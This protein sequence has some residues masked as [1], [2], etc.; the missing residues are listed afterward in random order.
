MSNSITYLTTRTTFLQVSPDIPVTK[1]RPEEKYDPPD[2]FDAN[3]KEM[4]HDLIVKAKQVEYL[5]NSLPAPEPE[6]EQAKRLGELEEEMRVVN[7][8]YVRALE[9]TSEYY[10]FFSCA[11]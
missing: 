1:S 4:V 7:E 6:E 3:K 9:R 11:A 10:D 5:I 8:D 2:M